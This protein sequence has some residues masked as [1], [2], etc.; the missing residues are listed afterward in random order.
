MMALVAHSS[1]VAVRTP[2]VLV[3]ASAVEARSTTGISGKPY[4][5]TLVGNNFFSACFSFLFLFFLFFLL[6]FFLLFL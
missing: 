1:I 4:Q 5:G 3:N 2:C 6:F